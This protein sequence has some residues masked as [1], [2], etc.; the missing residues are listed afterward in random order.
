MRE[1]ASP[2]HQTVH[3]PSVQLQYSNKTRHRLNIHV[4]DC[5]VVL[6]QMDILFF[7]SSLP[8]GCNIVDYCLYYLTS[9][10]A[11]GNGP[12]LRVVLCVTVVVS[13]WLWLGC[14]HLTQVYLIKLT[15]WSAAVWIIQ[16]RCNWVHFF[17]VCRPRPTIRPSLKAELVCW[18]RGDCQPTTY[19]VVGLVEKLLFPVKVVGVWSVTDLWHRWSWPWTVCFIPFC[20]WVIALFYVFVFFMI[21]VLINYLLKFYWFSFF[22]HGWDGWSN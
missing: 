5:V 10:F 17:S 6:L 12:S 1:C 22:A 20:K 9:I 11:V 2:G 7:Y 19:R 16:L 4:T 3:Q 14:A 15:L 8:V 21:T 13:Q 18:G